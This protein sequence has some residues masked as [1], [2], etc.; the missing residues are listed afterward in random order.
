MPEYQEFPVP[1]HSD[2]TK[3]A[4][5]NAVDIVALSA[6]ICRFA[7]PVPSSRRCVRFMTTTIPR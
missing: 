5:K 1:R 3:A 2:A 6:S 4:I 7:G